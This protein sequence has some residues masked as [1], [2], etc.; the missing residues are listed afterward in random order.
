MKTLSV[1]AAVLN[2]TPLDWDGNE[3]RILAALAAARA[4]KVGVLCLPEMCITGYGCEDAFHGVDVARQAER[5]LLELLPETKGLVTCFGLPWLH[6]RALFNAVAVVADGRLLGFVAKQNLAG[7]GIH[8]EPRWFKEW[9]RDL[10]ARTRCGSFDVPIGDLLFEVGGVRFGFEICEDAWVAERPG[11]RLAAY[12][13]DLILNPSASHFAFGKIEVRRQFVTEGSRAFGAAYVYS[14]LLGNEAGRAI[15]DGGALIATAGGII[16]QGPRL[17]MNDFELTRAV[18]DLASARAARA[19][20]ASFDPILTEHP[21]LVPV[22]HTWPEA[23]PPTP[24]MAPLA[25]WEDSPHFKEE[26]FARAEALAL[27]DYLRKARAQGYCVSLSG[28]CDST[29]TAVLV[30]LMVRR[31]LEDLGASGLRARLGHIKSLDQ[32]ETAAEFTAKLLTTAYQGSA[33]S[34]VVTRE[35]ARSVATSIGARHLEIDIESFVREYVSTIETTIGRKLS[36]TDDDL[37]LQNVQA[38]V[39]APGIWLVANLEQKLLLAT[40]NRTEAAVGYATMDGDTAG[41]LSPLAGVDKAFLRRWLSWLETSGPAGH[42]PM[43][44]VAAVTRQRS[45]PELRP[46]AAGQKSEDDLMPFDVLDR[47]ERLG[48]RDKL[49]PSDVLVELSAEYPETPREQLMAW[50]ERFFTL[51]CRNQWKRERLAPAFHVDDENLDPKTWCRFPILSGGF[52]RELRELRGER[53]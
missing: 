38:R 36:W 37:A 11:A 16:A 47:I 52:Q 24:R 49:S 50:I 19:R 48:I 46:P 7:D 29:V 28:G 23:G 26:E 8:Y 41:G 2:Q 53:S 6:H 22:E 4:E 51:W 12:G 14:N 9:R 35:A 33:N 1:A 17:T 31:G 30:H 27:L 5:V 40:S 39:R 32:A 20:T 21:G 42:G 25:A 45:T 18:V 43:P 34:S 10:V 15:Y 13:A 3:R 44:A